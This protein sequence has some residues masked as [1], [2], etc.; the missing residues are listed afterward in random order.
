MVGWPDICR[1]NVPLDR[2][3]LLTLFN[4]DL[5]QGV[6]SAGTREC[7]WTYGAARDPVQR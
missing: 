6:A 7:S 4:S 1:R 2:V 5:I 3:R